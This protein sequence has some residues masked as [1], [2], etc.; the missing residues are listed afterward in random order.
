MDILSELALKYGTDKY[1]HG[2]S[3]IYNNLLCNK[4]LM[5]YFIVIFKYL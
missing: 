2:F 1:N 5:N 4:K 3:Q